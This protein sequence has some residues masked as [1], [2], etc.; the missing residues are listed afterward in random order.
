MLDQVLDVDVNVAEPSAITPILG[1]AGTGC[2]VDTLVRPE[3]HIRQAICHALTHE[4]LT[5]A[6]NILRSQ[7]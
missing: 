2:Q 6:M 1:V 4:L 7:P 5:D 3:G